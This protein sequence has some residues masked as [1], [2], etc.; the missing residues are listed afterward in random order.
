[1]DEATW[2]TLPDVAERLGIEVG[3]VRQLLRDGHLLARRV[4]DGPLEV[5]EA[6]L[7]DGA[8][9]KGLPGT[10][11]LLRDARFTDD[12]AV[13]WLFA[14]SDALGAAP[15]SA[16]QQKRIHEVRRVAAVQVF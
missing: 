15:I 11:T 8:V 16:L 4:D 1:M 2:L 7:S 10:I 12:E 3:K 5:A 6:F 13:E 14:H 9:L